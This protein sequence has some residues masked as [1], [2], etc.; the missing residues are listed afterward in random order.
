M[1]CGFGPGSNAGVDSVC[2]VYSPSKRSG[3]R[4]CQCSRMALIASTHSRMCATGRPNSP[5]KRFSTCGLDLRA[6]AE[7]EAA[8][9]Q[10]LQVVRRVGEV[11]RTAR[12]RD[13]HVGHQVEV[14]H[15]RRRDQRE[16][17]VVRVLEAEHAVDAERLQLGS[18]ARGLHHG[19]GQLHVDLHGHG[20]RP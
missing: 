3:V 14:A 4:S 12:E 20:R 10:L 17:E 1:P 2:R 8:A 6:E 16:E 11:P 18:P 9:R 7:A 15:R 5:P 13:G 19:L